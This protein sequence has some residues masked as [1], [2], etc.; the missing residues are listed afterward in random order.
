MVLLF[1]NNRSLQALNA[2]WFCLSLIDSALQW[3]SQIIPMAFTTPFPSIYIGSPWILGDW[4]IFFCKITFLFYFW[5]SVDSIDCKSMV[6]REGRTMNCNHE[7]LTFCNPLWFFYI[8]FPSIFHKWIYL[9]LFILC[10]C[11]LFLCVQMNMCVGTCI[12]FKFECIDGSKHLC[13]V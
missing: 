8:V 7:G 11:A 2:L 12:C 9:W 5:F 1:I 3:L 6:V 13:W 4:Y 10:L